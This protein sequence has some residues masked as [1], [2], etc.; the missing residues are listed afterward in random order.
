[1]LP[2]RRDAA[3]SPATGPT[4]RE[5]LTRPPGTS[6]PSRAWD[7]A[8]GCRPRRRGFRMTAAAVLADAFGRIRGGVHE[9]VD[10][11]KPGELTYR[12]DGE[13]NSVAWLV[14]ALTRIKNHH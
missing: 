10:G 9:V 12:P 3:K 8:G 4:H 11:R 14:W 5:P 1:M 13:G 2:P 6:R 7:N